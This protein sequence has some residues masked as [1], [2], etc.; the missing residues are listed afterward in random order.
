MKKKRESKSDRPQEELSAN[1]LLTI[2][3]I[4]GLSITSDTT[5]ATLTGCPS[6]ISKTF[7]H[8]TPRKVESSLD[9]SNCSI[10]KVSSVAFPS[11]KM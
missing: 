1:I 11:R 6:G 10:E 3:E 7:N 5:S 9:I 8:L 4:K 2:V